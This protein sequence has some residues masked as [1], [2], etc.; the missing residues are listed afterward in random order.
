[1]VV[2]SVFQHVWR[3]H[4]SLHDAIWH[5]ATNLRITGSIFYTAQSLQ[6]SCWAERM[7]I[8]RRVSAERFFFSPHLTWTLVNKPRI[9]WRFRFRDF[10]LPLI[11]HVW[12]QSPLR[13]TQQSAVQT[14]GILVNEM[15]VIVFLIAGS[16]R[17][18][19]CDGFKDS[20]QRLKPSGL[21][22]EAFFPRGS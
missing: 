14:K 7:K 9:F 3:L 15:M 5:A 4:L 20:W 10:I 1:M 18:E 13:F 22:D 21:K 12:G 17:S 6:R 11:F 2:I 19:V 8:S 16:G